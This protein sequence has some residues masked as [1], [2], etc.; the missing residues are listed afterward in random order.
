MGKLTST[1][2]IP[3]KLLNEAQ[4]RSHLLLFPAWYIGI[5]ANAEMRDRVTSSPSKL[6]PASSTEESSW[7]VRPHPHHHLSRTILSI[8]NRSS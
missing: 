7:R 5:K 1:I 8:Q 2:G 3:I 4:V 6:H